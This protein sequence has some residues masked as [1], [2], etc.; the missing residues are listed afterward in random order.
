MV[1]DPNM[2]IGLQPDWIRTYVD[3]N[4]FGLIAPQHVAQRGQ[5]Q[6]E[7]CNQS[8]TD[9]HGFTELFPILH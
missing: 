1:T 8:E 4:G 2:E 9:V 3:D 5:D 6:V 7:N